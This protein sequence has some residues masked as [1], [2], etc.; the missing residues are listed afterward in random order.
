MFI[1]SP[2]DCSGIRATRL[3]R[4]GG[5]SAVAGALHGPDGVAIGVLFSSISQLYFRGKLEYAECFASQD[6]TGP[7]IRIVTPTVGLVRPDL[8]VRPELFADFAKG[9]IDVDEETYRTPL[10]NT[11]RREAGS[12]G[13]NRV[14]FLGSLATSK[15]LEPLREVFSTALYVP[16]V[17]VGMGNMKRGSVLLEAVR[18]GRELE[19]V[20]AGNWGEPA[21]RR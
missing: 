1:L 14:V 17:F 5:S 12:M 15:Y 11:A 2:A 20:R 8:A 10:L 18:E 16:R 9:S 3:L 7:A 19:Y 21:A 13:A 6:E 4:G